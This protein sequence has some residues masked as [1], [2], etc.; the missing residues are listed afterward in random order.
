ML[1]CDTFNNVRLYLLTAYFRSD[2]RNPKNYFSCQTALT[3]DMCT[4]LCTCPL[5]SL[6]VFIR[7]GDIRGRNYFVIL[8]NAS[9]KRNGQ[10]TTTYILKRKRNAT[11]SKMV[12]LSFSSKNSASDNEISKYRYLFCIQHQNQTAVPYGWRAATINVRQPPFLMS[13]SSKNCA[14]FAKKRFNSISVF[15]SKR[16]DKI[17][18]GTFMFLSAFILFK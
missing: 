5:L 17:K 14:Y 3:K 10:S 18:S 13:Q 1:V 12:V 11:L 6:V 8:C 9:M 4:C 16:V 15:E 2:V 7:S